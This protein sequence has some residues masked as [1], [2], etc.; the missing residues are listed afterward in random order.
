MKTS[1]Q[2]PA[3]NDN[4]P[5]EIPS[6]LNE[7]CDYVLYTARK[8]IHYLCKASL[9]NELVRVRISVSIAAPCGNRTVER[10]QLYIG[11]FYLTYLTGAPLSHILF[12]QRYVHH[13][14]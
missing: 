13:H 3:G 1:A 9:V 5:H 11:A 10:H 4:R 8:T 12:K 7:A 14:L 2:A 6:W